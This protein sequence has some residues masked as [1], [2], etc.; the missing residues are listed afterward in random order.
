MNNWNPPPGVKGW[1]SRSLRELIQQSDEE[2][3]YRAHIEDYRASIREEEQGRAKR[4]A[5]SQAHRD[6]IVHRSMVRG[7]DYTMTAL[8]LAAEHDGR[9]DIVEW[10]AKQRLPTFGDGH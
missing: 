3:A 6:G 7:R 10:L 4:E 1:P 2:E 8:R 9:E 5:Y